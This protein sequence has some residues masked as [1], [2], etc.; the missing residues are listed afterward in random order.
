MQPERYRWMDPPKLAALPR[1]DLDFGL[2]VW[3]QYCERWHRH[4]EDYGHRVAHCDYPASPYKE[5]GYVLC[6]P[7]AER[8]WTLSAPDDWATTESLVGAEPS[9]RAG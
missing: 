1:D 5:T 3:C 9:W 4:G 2:Q 7:S 8:A 6:D